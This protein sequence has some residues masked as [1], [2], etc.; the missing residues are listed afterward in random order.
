MPDQ[1]RTGAN[2]TRRSHGATQQDTP[3][4]RRPTQNGAR[5]PQTR[6][7]NRD[8]ARTGSRTSSQTEPA[9]PK[10]EQT[11][12]QAPPIFEKPDF[13]AIA[14]VASPFGLR[15]AVKANI[16]SDFPERFEQLTKV[17]LSPPG[18]SP[19]NP[20]ARQE[21]DLL[22]ARLQSEKQVVFRFEGIT[23]VEQA[24]ELRGYTISIPVEEVVPLPEG[25]Y[26]IFQI[27]GLDVYTTDE[28]YVGRVINVERL[29]ANDV[30]V[31]RGPLS[32]SDVLLPAI[33]DVIKEIDLEEGRITV[34]LMEGLIS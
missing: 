34:E 30:Y 15:G 24:E 33:K 7:P 26:Y 14:Q 25:E 12:E 17:F 3:K 19:N 31:V 29:P 9:T 8:Q 21:R 22:S 16:Q 10:V 27:V 20:E 5:K 32:K 13:V 18:A 2:R 1:K 11:V 6:R 4:G 23:K 28:Q